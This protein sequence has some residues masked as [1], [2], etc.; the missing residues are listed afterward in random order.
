MENEIDIA[1]NK[2]EI[3]N[4]LFDQ[5]IE[6]R[7]SRDG[8]IDN[9]KNLT[10][11]DLRN[12]LQE[13]AYLIFISGNEYVTT[14]EILSNDDMEYYLE[15]IGDSHLSGTLKGILISF[16]FK[17]RQEDVKQGEPAGIEFFH[18][19]LQEYL[20][21]ERI[22]ATMFRSFLIKDQYGQYIIR[23]PSDFL[24]K[25]NEIFGK[26][27]ISYEIQ[28]DIK[29]LLAKRSSEEKSELVKRLLFAIGYLFEKDFIYKV[30]PE[31]MNPIHNGMSTFLSFWQF[32][33]SLETETN[34]MTSSIVQTRYAAYYQFLKSAEGFGSPYHYI[35]K[36]RFIEL[37][38][39][40]WHLM[41][42]DVINTNF[43]RCDI[44]EIS[45]FDARVENVFFEATD[46]YQL[47]IS[48]C[49][50]KQLKLTD[51]DISTL[52]IYKI[53]GRIIFEN[54]EFRSEVT[55]LNKIKKHSVIFKK[56]IFHGNIDPKDLQSANLIGCTKRLVDYQ[57]KIPKKLDVPIPDTLS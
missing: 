10:K 12:M 31:E 13:I 46:I 23:K 15:K 9:L 24:I 30:D 52:R 50:V 37:D 8:Q 11:S 19:S 53:K 33:Q 41:E 55:I 39:K 45:F 14:T 29:Q 20:T 49:T 7:Y 38:I 3:Y 17:E 56:C 47:D 2:A 4:R 26:M 43:T 22:V 35:S 44:N 5:I 18:K 25:L 34:F 16:Y 48:D 28:S 54:C 36:Q 40:E 1:S 6:R 51:C 57:S 21:A 32:V 42:E 27:P